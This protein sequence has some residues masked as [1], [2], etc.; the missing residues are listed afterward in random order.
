[1]RWAIAAVVFT[2]LLEAQQ[3]RVVSEFNRIGPDGLTV[4]ADR[5][6]HPREILSPAVARNAWA[7]FRVVVEAPA[8]VPYYLYIGQN[9]EKSVEA[10]IYQE[11]Y[12]K[13]GE[14]WVSDGLKPVK[15]PVPGVLTGDQ[16]AQSY[17]LDLWV[18]QATPAG[19]FRVEVQLNIDDRWIIYPMEFRA[20]NVEAPRKAHAG[21][22]VGEPGARSDAAIEWAVSEYLCG[23]RQAGASEALNARSIRDRNVRQDLEI[24]RER[25]RINAGKT[26]RAEVAKAAGYETAEAFREARGPAPGGAEWWLKARAFIYQGAAV[27]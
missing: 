1:M 21:L 2:H 20:Q 25:E 26:A 8:G 27:E 15:F 12:A 6:E 14:T 23:V 18:P 17:L 5:V 4:A 10:A 19:R 16:K 7:T 22:A 13:T 3:V 11:E 24:L 9:P